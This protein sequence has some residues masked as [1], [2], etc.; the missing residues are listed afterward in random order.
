[1]NIRKRAIGSKKTKKPFSYLR[2]SY[3]LLFGLI[4]IS[5]GWYFF[6]LVRKGYINP[7]GE[8]DLLTATNISPFLGNF[9]APFVT[10][11]SALLV[12][13]N[14]REVRR[15]NEDAN[16]KTKR[17]ATLKQCQTYYI[18]LQ[19]AYKELTDKGVP[20][21]LVMVSNSLVEP[22]KSELITNNSDWNAQINCI[23]SVPDYHSITVLYLNKLESFSAC[24]LHGGLDLEF[25]KNLIGKH[26]VAQT[27]GLLAII[28]YYRNENSRY[29]AQN[30]IELYKLWGGSINDI[31]DEIK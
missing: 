5:I 1:M 3:R 19:V 15:N 4:T 12:L 26:Y 13:E 18:D 22:L 7:R 2:L 27:K 29:F 30:S 24:F 21:T 6:N 25:G 9:I 16:A 10:L 28:A 14:L 8:F 23:L 11:A 31:L 20:G 17:E